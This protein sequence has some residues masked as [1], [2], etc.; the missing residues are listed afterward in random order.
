MYLCTFSCLR[1]RHIHMYKRPRSQPDIEM[2]NFLISGC[3][4]LCPDDPPD[5]FQDCV[6]ECMA[7]CNGRN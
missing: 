5:M 3:L 6:Q 2:T 1:H 4:A 7:L